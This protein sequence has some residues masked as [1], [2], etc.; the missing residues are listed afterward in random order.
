MQSRMAAEVEQV[1]QVVETAVLKGSDSR[2]AWVARASYEVARAEVPGEVF[3]RRPLGGYAEPPARAASRI[4]CWRARHREV[5][6]LE[7]QLRTAP[8]GQREALQQKLD[9]ERRGLGGG[10]DRARRTHGTARPV[11]R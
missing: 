6:R 10:A 3:R 7:E 11:A 4:P 8:E 9:A 2:E 5:D 1:R